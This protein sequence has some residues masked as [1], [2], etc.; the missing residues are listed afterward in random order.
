MLRAC[1]RIVTPDASVMLASLQP[2]LGRELP[3]TRVSATIANGELVMHIEADDTTS[4]RAALNSYLG[5]MKISEDIS[6][7]IG[8]R[9]E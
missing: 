4:M 7:L 6:G 9:Y 5:W 8:D 2:E 1:L 3:R